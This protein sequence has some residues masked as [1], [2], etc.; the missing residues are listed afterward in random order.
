MMARR[1]M[2]LRTIT[3]S[4]RVL[5][6]GAAADVRVPEHGPEADE[7]NDY[8]PHFHIDSNYTTSHLTES[9]A[10]EWNVSTAKLGQ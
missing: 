1:A 6:M 9:W 5:V 7:A 10:T 4:Q 8:A 3:A 2:N